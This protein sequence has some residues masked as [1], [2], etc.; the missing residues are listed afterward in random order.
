MQ[1]QKV[2]IVSGAS[3]GLGASL[4]EQ[5]LARGYRVAAISRNKS[6]LSELEN[7]LTSDALI[8]L[9]SDVTD[10]QQVDSAID[11]IIEKFG[12]IDVVFN[13]AALYP[14]QNFIDQSIEDF[15]LALNVN[16]SGI[17]NIAKATVPIM[18]KQGAG[19][20]INLGSWAHLGPIADAAVYSASKGAVHS[21]SKGMAIDLAAKS[22]PISVIEWIPGHLNTQMSDYT[23][24]DPSVAAAWGTDLV[25]L[26]LAGKNH[27]IYEQNWEWQPPK[28]LKQ[29]IKNKLFFWKK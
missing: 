13:N 18:Q 26:Q 8:A 10:A 12:R 22:L 17:V 23:G 7:K 14:K 16:I 3:G 21:L 24:M 11:T 2:V 27:A 20:I 25:E 19:T 1:D 4:C 6:A 5:L 29:K 9:P 15:N 28:G